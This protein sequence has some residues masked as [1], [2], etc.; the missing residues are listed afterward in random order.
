MIIIPFKHVH[1]IAFNLL[2]LVD[3]QFL[4]NTANRWLLDY[5]F[6]PLTQ[7]HTSLLL[8]LSQFF[9]RS[10]SHSLSDAMTRCHTTSQTLLN[11]V[12]FDPSFCKKPF[13]HEA[14]LLVQRLTFRCLLSNASFHFKNLDS[15][16]SILV[17]TQKPNHLP[18]KFNSSAFSCILRDYM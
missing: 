3:L 2:W 18:T 9:S 16:S 17:S 5:L 14:T 4:P 13:L 1:T 7:F 10:S 11:C 6:S 15:K 8:L 12:K